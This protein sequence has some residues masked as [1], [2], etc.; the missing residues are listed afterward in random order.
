MNLKKILS[1]FGI[2]L[3]LSLTLSHLVFSNQNIQ[4][5]ED[6]ASTIC[7]APL[8]VRDSLI[9]SI[10]FLCLPGIIDKLIEYREIEC[11]YAICSYNSII[12]N[13]DDSFNQNFNENCLNYKNYKTCTY[14]LG[15]ISAI[16]L[17][18]IIDN[19]KKAIY[20][21]LSNPLSVLV[22]G[23]RHYIKTVCFGKGTTVVV[24]SG[25]CWSP[26]VGVFSLYL[27]S[28]DIPY[29]EKRL[30]DIANSPPSFKSA[31]SCFQIDEIEDELLKI[32]EDYESQFETE[33]EDED[34]SSENGESGSSED[35]FPDV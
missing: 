25:L 16:P 10:G 19:I 33:E 15:E 6:I 24:K 13:S 2:Y 32:I 23:Y 12:Y 18:K 29:A 35:E 5:R 34:E 9:L 11:Q 31:S 1:L 3:I 26:F 27:V 21:F 20:T 4:K 8:D 14:V 22:A 30:R 17:V 7:G 28:I